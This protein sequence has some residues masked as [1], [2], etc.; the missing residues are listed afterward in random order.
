MN[1]VTKFGKLSILA[2]LVG[3]T[4][5][6]TLKAQNATKSSK[7]TVA[8]STIAE[9]APVLPKVFFSEYIEGSSN[10][11]AIEI[12]NAESDSVDLSKFKI[13][14]ANNGK[15]FEAASIA[16]VLPLQGKLGPGKTFVIANAASDAAILAK[17]DT[18]FAYDAA[19]AGHNVSAFNGDDALGLFYNDSLLVDLF[20]DPNNDPGSSWKIDTTGT[21]AD[22]TLVRKRGKIG[23]PMVLGSF[24]TDSTASEWIVY[25]KDT[26]DYLGAH[27]FEF[28]KYNVTFKVDMNAAIDS[29]NFVA[30]KHNVLVRG[31]FNNWGDADTLKDANTDGIY[32]LT[33]SITEGTYGYKFFVTSLEYQAGQ[34][35]GNERSLVVDG[36]KVLDVVKTDIEFKNLTGTTFD[37]VAIQFQVNMQVQILKGVFNKATDIIDV[38]GNFNGWSGGTNL[39]EGATQN[40]FEAVVKFDDYALGG[41][42]VYK[43][44]TTIGGA[45]NWESP[46]NNNPDNNRVFT[47]ENRVYTPEER[48]EGYVA[49][50]LNEEGA[51]PFFSD[52]TNNDIFTQESTVTFR[53]DLRPAYYFLAD[54]AKLPSDVQ[55]ADTVK[56]I[57]GLFANGPFL[58]TGAGGWEAWGEASLGTRE[59]L[60]LV[61]D[62]KLGDD[63]AGDS[64]Y[65]RTFTFAPGRDKIGPYKFGINGIDNEAYAGENHRANVKDGDVVNVIY[66]AIL[67]SNG[68][69]YKKL[70]D[71]YIGIE[72]GTNRLYVRRNS[73][74]T[75]V[76]VEDNNLATP[77]RFELSQN[78]PNPFNPS[79]TI[80]FSLPKAA[81]VT[82]NVYNVLGQKVATLIN[83]QAMGL[84]THNL[85][86]DASRL[87]SGMYIYRIQAGSFTSA[88][89]MTLIK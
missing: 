30:A 80:S 13:I 10:N 72:E 47:I 29:A 36:D 52:I 6:S 2:L 39:T 26:F 48:L 76:S 32:E 50:F 73:T 87:A 8:S 64:I 88:K 33:K 37:K 79:T 35:E 4:G 78:Y 18:T 45:T 1:K 54:S 74:G 70:Y 51:A 44:T 83:G 89:T 58:N 38:R 31:A 53:V 46:N 5:F 85:N 65:S 27:D 12:Y 11:K 59:D 9:D 20:G 62:G 63:V 81:N 22:F 42:L 49:V 68:S 15:T 17:A 84:G 16:Y 28:P 34:W 82:L 19:A 14:Q 7:M 56:S 69:I 40:V 23:N 41:N 60:R 57:R 21:T 24:G 61:D 75:E 3:L 25:P 86:F 67:L 66:G 77:A 55:N 43:F 71:P